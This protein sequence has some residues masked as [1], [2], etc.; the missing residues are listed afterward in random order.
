VRT[1]GQQQLPSGASLGRHSRGSLYCWCHPWP[2]RRAD[3]ANGAASATAGAATH[4]GRARSHRVADDAAAC[5]GGSQ[6]G[7]AVAANACRAVRLPKLT[8]SPM[9]V[10]VPSVVPKVA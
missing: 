9:P 4:A 2:P 6:G 7:R 3:L 5:V 8:L 1:P 10:V